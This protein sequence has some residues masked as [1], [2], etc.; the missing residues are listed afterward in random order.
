[1]AELEVEVTTNDTK[2]M[3]HE[4]GD[5]LFTCV[6]LSRKLGIDPETALRHAN[7]RF[8]SRFGY[9]ENSLWQQ[10]RDIAKTDLEELEMLWTE[11]KSKE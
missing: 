9:I 5:V 1:M 11:A 4:M 7:T 2:A 6:N 10:G 3:E 8:E